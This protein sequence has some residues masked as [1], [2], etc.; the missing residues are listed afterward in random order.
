MI[1][2]RHVIVGTMV[3]VFV[4]LMV[5]I[6]LMN[7]EFAKNQVMP[8]YLVPT[9]V[10]SIGLF[11]FANTYLMIER[12]RHVTT[13]KRIIGISLTMISI[14]FFTLAVI[15]FPLMIVN[16]VSTN[17]AFSVSSAAITIFAIIYSTNSV[18]LNR[19]FPKH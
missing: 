15:V 12:V 18:L 14:V 7:V 5:Q 10:S 6:S 17:I 16:E 8:V 19:F 1:R 13:W 11:S 2:L 3:I 9:L 4:F